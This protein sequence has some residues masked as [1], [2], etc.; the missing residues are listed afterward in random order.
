[1]TRLAFVIALTFCAAI[2]SSGTAIAQTP[3][4]FS[5]DWAFEGPAAPFLV[6]L[7]R[8]F[9]KEEG[10]DVEI[11]PGAGSVDAVGRVATGAYDMALGDINS[12]IRFRPRDDEVRPLAVFMLYDRS[13]FAIVGRKSRGISDPR[14]LE[15]KTLGAPKS[16]GAFA[17]WPLFVK[18]NGIETDDIRIVN[19]G[20]AVREP[21]LAAGEVDAV[22]GYSW[23]AAI[24][25]R[26][27]GVPAN[28][29]VVLRMADYG[30]DLYGNALM[31][32]PA[33][34]K[35]NPEAV[36][37]FLRALI[38]GL[39]AVIAEP[40]AALRSVVDRNPGA[41]MDVE[42]E[43]LKAALD[44][45]I[46]P[47]AKENGLGDVDV[48]RLARSI[49]LIAETQNPEEMPAATDIFDASYLPPKGERLLDHS[50][51]SGPRAEERGG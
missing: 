32:A 7:D 22:T 24:N 21:M 3:L 15:G 13:P 46:T 27:K 9:F 35:D 47:E 45:I 18:A 14:S 31:V 11:E 38:R 1:M 40:D 29:I 43:R 20:F 48:E 25:L 17:Q 2:A 23:S 8:G 5:L 50:A 28:D 6:A 49:A 19:L 51:S 4:R 16:D 37:G 36:K 12:L 42:R 26:D 41:R 44:A 10:L 34:A 39:K 33:F 30:V